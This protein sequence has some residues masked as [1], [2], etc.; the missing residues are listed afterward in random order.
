MRIAAVALGALLSLGALGC[1]SANK[2]ANEFADKIC[3]CKD[4]E[5]VTKVSEEAKAWAEK[6]T[7][8]SGDKKEMEKTATRISECM[9]KLM[10]SGAGLGGEKKEEGGEKKE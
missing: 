8:A 6:N 5:C 2:K 10:K 3:A 9:S 7:D 4:M 1:S